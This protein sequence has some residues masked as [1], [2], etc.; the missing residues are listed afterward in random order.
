M[1]SCSESVICATC[2]ALTR[3]TTTVPEHISLW[4]RTRPTPEPSRPSAAFFR[5]PSSA[6]YTTITSG[7][8]LREGHPL[9]D[10]CFIHRVP[11]WRPAQ[12][13][14]RAS[15]AQLPRRGREC[16]ELVAGRSG[17]KKQ[18]ENDVD[19]ITSDVLAGNDMNDDIAGPT[20]EIVHDETAV[21][22]GYHYRLAARTS[23]G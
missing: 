1:R 23:P 10:E 3:I 6:D 16:I 11:I 15:I 12:A 14:E 17:R 7:S 5:C 2:C 13:G 4:P 22:V 20:N 8:N 19:G 9:C 18:Q 21:G